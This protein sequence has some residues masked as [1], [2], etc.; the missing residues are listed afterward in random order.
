MAHKIKQLLY[1]KT[2][3]FKL[4]LLASPL[5]IFG[6][7]AKIFAATFFAGINFTYLTTPFLKYFALHEGQDPYQF[8]FQ[9]GILEVFP[10]PQLMLYILSFFGVLF[11]FFL[12]V[13]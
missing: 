1:D 5:F 12:N 11:S 7:V 6:L 13:W 9:S 4:T 10:Y 2:G 8:F 3:A